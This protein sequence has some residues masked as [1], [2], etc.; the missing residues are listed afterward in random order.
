[1]LYR[2]SDIISE[3]RV[4]ISDTCN[5]VPRRSVCRLGTRLGQNQ[6]S[7]PQALYVA[8]LAVLSD[9]GV[10]NRRYQHVTVRRSWC[11]RFYSGDAS[12]LQVDQTVSW[13]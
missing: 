2:T 13:Q 11:E 9:Y 12:G 1:M 6:L 7:R 4:S 3:P 10:A 8:E 5:L